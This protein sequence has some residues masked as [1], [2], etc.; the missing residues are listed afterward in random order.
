[1]IALSPTQVNAIFPDTIAHKICDEDSS[2]NLIKFLALY[3]SGDEQQLG[4]L[5]LLD[6]TQINTTLIQQILAIDC[7]QSLYDNYN[8]WQTHTLK[9]VFSKRA[10]HKKE[11]S[12]NELLHRI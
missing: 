6:Y 5:N 11:L 3:L 4:N 8:E 7:Q 12:L 2:N 9:K 1:M 10:F